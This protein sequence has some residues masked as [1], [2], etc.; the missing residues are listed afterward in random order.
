M[1]VKYGETKVI[2]PKVSKA[3]TTDPIAAPDIAM[4]PN[5]FLYKVLPSY[6]AGKDELS[7]G[8]ASMV[9][10]TLPIYCVVDVSAK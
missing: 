2:S 5:P 9:A 1:Y 10:E 4:P 3:P 6:I 8:T 7:P